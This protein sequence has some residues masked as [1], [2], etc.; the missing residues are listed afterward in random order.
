M[1]PPGL[2]LKP[3]PP[4]VEMQS[5]DPWTTR[6]VLIDYFKMCFVLVLSFLYCKRTYKTF[7]IK[8][9]SVC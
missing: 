8:I 5:L 9:S 3:V 1:K 6:E 4:A 7:I 2:G